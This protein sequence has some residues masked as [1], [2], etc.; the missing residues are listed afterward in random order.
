MAVFCRNCGNSMND[1]ARFCST[2]GAP[3]HPVAAPYNVATSRLIR[4]R[5]GRMIAGVCQG[6]A[7]NY[8]WDVA[9]VRVITVLLSVFGGGAGIIAYV[10]FWIVMPEEALALPPN[11]A[12]PGTTYV[13]PAN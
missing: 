4:P 3:L 5:A 13:P 12:P 7:N 9:V 1:D 11:T 8:N 6:L 2:C 10:V